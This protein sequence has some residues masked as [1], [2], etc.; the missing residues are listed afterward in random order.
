MYFVSCRKPGTACTARAI[1]GLGVER[2][3]GMAPIG[4]LYAPAANIVCRNEMQK[5]QVDPTK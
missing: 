3:E 5:R 1:L 2:G 4:L